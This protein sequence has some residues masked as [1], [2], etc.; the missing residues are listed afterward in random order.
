MAF[1]EVGN[2]WE[3][4]FHFQWKLA[5]TRRRTCTLGGSQVRTKEI[6]S[7]TSVQLLNEFKCLFIHILST[8]SYENT[9]W[10]FFFLFLFLSENLLLGKMGWKWCG[11]CYPRAITSGLIQRSCHLC[12]EPLWWGSVRGMFLECKMLLFF[13]RHFSVL[14]CER[15]DIRTIHMNLYLTLY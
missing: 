14:F 1:V 15:I 3:I 13:S 5:K 8:I 4:W 12:W 7:L 6:S 2:N 11:T 9:S 10:F